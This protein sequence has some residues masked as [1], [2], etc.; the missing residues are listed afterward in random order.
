MK[1]LTLSSV[2]RFAA[3]III[4]MGFGGSSLGGHLAWPRKYPQRITSQDEAEQLPAHS[5]LAFVCAK[6]QTMSGL[7]SRETR[8]FVAWFSTTTTHGCTNCHG[9][10]SLKRTGAFKPGLVLFYTHQCSKCGESSAFL[11]ASLRA[12]QRSTNKKGWGRKA[13]ASATLWRAD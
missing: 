1:I 12:R 10:V 7:G 11:C 4:I 2:I 5:N 8:S 9:E 13:G 3:V 6:C